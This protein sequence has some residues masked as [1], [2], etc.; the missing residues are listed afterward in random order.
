MLLMIYL[1]NIS[2]R[3]FVTYT[4]A[5]FVVCVVL[6]Q[7]V[8]ALVFY[9]I[10]PQVIFSRNLVPNIIER[11]RASSNT[12]KPD[13]A[14]L[15]T[16][17]RFPRIGLPFAS[18]GNP[19]V[20]RYVLSRGKLDPEYYVAVVG[21]YN[22]EG[23]KR[24]LRDVSK[25]EHILIPDNLKLNTASSSEPASPCAGYLKSLRQWFLY[26][27]KLPCRAEPLDANAA[28]RSFIGDHFTVIDHID[29]WLLLRRNDDAS[30]P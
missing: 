20:E 30:S 5:Y 4:A 13:L 2:W 10:S 7:L 18:F 11:F 28:L 19:A 17:D 23:L 1:A 3:A 24:K 16:L 14:K 15:S 12:R 29:S 21:V 25:M 27:A 8:N 6:M 22:A 9:G 26:P